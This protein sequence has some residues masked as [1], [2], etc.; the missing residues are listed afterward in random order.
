MLK[1]TIFLLFSLSF[2]PFSYSQDITIIDEEVTP[3]SST[4]ILYTNPSGVTVNLNSDGSIKSIMATGEAELIIGDRKDVRISL[5]KAEMRAKA[6]I[7]KFI[8]ESITSTQTLDEI[9]ETIT[10]YNSNGDSAA[11][12]DSIEKTTESISNSANEILK[13]VVTLLQDVDNE[14]KFV[15]VTVGINDKTLQ[16]SN[17]VKNDIIKENS[18][19]MKSIHST[20]PSNKREVRKSNMMDDF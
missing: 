20:E 10:A 18:S 3:N 5:Q 6:S 8:S 4:D 11:T 1:K 14:N 19:T 7:A 9:T 15:M 2:I 13:G 17:A 12:R 16:A